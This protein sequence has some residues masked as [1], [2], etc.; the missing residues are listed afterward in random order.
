MKFIFLFGFLL[1]LVNQGS[2]QNFLKSDDYLEELNQRFMEN[3]PR[4]AETLRRLF[5]NR[6]LISARTK[7]NNWEVVPRDVEMEEIPFEAAME[8]EVPS[9]DHYP[10]IRGVPWV[11]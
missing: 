7:N 9:Q 4:A 10:I 5:A 11:H 6:A 1:V 3:H 8:S 2:G